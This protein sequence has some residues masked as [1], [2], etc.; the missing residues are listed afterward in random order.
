MRAQRDNLITHAEA[1]AAEKEALGKNTEE[2]AEKVALVI[3]N[4]NAKSENCCI[5]VLLNLLLMMK[6]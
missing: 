3:V 2:L 4:F 6:H 1:I 5:F